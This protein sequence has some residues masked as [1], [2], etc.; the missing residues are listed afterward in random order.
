MGVCRAVVNVNTHL[1]SF[2]VTENVTHG[3]LG[4]ATVCTGA[5]RYWGY[6]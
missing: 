4:S 3:L 5:Q 6:P 2:D 1:A